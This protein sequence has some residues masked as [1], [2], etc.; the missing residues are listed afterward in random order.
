MFVMKVVT[1]YITMKDVKINLDKIL[2][3]VKMV[4]IKEK[5]I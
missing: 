1:F 3:Y 4:L 2:K 5:I